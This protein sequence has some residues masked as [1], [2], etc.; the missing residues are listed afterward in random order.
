MRQL[1]IFDCQEDTKHECIQK[2]DLV[3]L[4][5]LDESL[6]WEIHN[7]RKYYCEQWI[8]KIGTVLEIKKNTVEVQFLEQI[9]LCDVRELEWIA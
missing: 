6:D 5:L 7:Y 9:I 3:K 1:S 4:I 8:G 2:H